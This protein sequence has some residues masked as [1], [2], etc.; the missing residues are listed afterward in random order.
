MAGTSSFLY[1]RLARSL[2]TR[3][4]SRLAPRNAWQGPANTAPSPPTIDTGTY[5]PIVGVTVVGGK[6]AVTFRWLPGSDTETPEA[7]LTYS[8]RVWPSAGGNDVAPAMARIDNGR[9]FVAR[10]GPVRA[11]ASLCDWTVWLTVGVE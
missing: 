10:P 3:G 7:L 4:L 11:S 6:K 1:V 8:L 2:G 9:R 5:P